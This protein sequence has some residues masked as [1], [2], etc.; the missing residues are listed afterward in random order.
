MAEYSDYTQRTHSTYSKFNS[1]SLSCSKPNSTSSVRYRSH[2]HSNSSYN[3]GKILLFTVLTKFDDFLI[4]FRELEMD[5]SKTFWDNLII[6]VIV[7]MEM[8]IATIIVIVMEAITAM[9]IMIITIC[10]CFLFVWVW[11]IFFNRVFIHAILGLSDWWSIDKCGA[12]ICF[13]DFILSKN[14]ASWLLYSKLG[15]LICFANNSV[16]YLLYRNTHKFSAAQTWVC[17]WITSDETS[18]WVEK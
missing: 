5:P 6:V 8:E 14:Q 16:M 12:L 17:F 1:T 10:L 9:G 15:M 2:F 18:I 4:I 13:R 7:I 3:F 11:K